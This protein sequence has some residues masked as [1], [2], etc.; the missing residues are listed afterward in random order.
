MR[1]LAILIGSII[2]F[3]TFTVSAQDNGLSGTMWRLKEM[4]GR[5]VGDSRAYI[6]VD[7]ESGKLSGNGGC[8]RIF[9]AVTI[10]NR[11]VEVSHIGS[12][13]MMCSDEMTAEAE[14]K[15]TLKSVTR[16]RLNG[17]TLILFEGRKAVLRFNATS[18][19]DSTPDGKNALADKKWV[20][21]AIEG[22]VVGSNG[23]QAFI[24]F[25]RVRSSLGGNTSCNVFGGNLSID[26]DK[27]E[28][29]QGISTMR[30]CI[31]DDR[32]SIERSILDGLQNANRIEVFENKLTLF[33]DSK[34]LLTFFGIDK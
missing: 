15:T 34:V 7:T 12:T 9:A 27:F 8:N 33:R 18:D 2:G 21:H 23:E 3:W 31:E 29:S 16:Y 17:D 14:F 1:S 32:M 13:R 19:S 26:N 5:D 4:N 24:N 10:S 11:T 22:E 30:A 28:F 20:L 6:E 25:D